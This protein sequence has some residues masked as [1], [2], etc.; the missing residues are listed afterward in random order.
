MDYYVLSKVKVLLQSLNKTERKHD[1][2]YILTGKTY[3]LGCP[4]EYA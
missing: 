4:E 1:P 2:P 3:S